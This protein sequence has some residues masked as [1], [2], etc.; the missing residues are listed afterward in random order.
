MKKLLAGHSTI[1]GFPLPIRSNPVID[2]IFYHLSL[3]FVH[4]LLLIEIRHFKI[5][6]L[7]QPSNRSLMLSNHGS[8]HSGLKIVIFR[9]SYG[10]IQRDSILK[11]VFHRL[12]HTIIRIYYRLMFFL[13]LHEAL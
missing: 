7:R 13:T 10:L 5:C 1:L 12:K 3:P 4:N 9:R 8:L 2:H 11:G 6:R